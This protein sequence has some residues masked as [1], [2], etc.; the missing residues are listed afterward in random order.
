MIFSRFFKPK[1][2]HKDPDVRRQ[3]LSDLDASDP[4][5]R[6]LLQELAQR[7]ASADVRLAALRRVDDPQWWREAAQRDEAP[8]VRER[9]W[10]RYVKLFAGEGS[11]PLEER[12]SRLASESDRLVEHVLRHGREADLRRAALTRLERESAYAERVLKDEDPAIRLEALARIGD[13]NTLERLLKQTRTRDKRVATAIKERLAALQA[14]EERP[15]VLRQRAAALCGG[16]D[17]L[18][19]RARLKGEWETAAEQAAMHAEWDALRGECESCGLTDALA[20]FGPRYDHARARLDEGYAAYASEQAEQRARAALYEPLREEKAA[21][22]AA[23][24]RLLQDLGECAAP[25]RSE[26]DYA[27]RAWAVLQNNWRELEPLPPQEEQALQR[28]YDEIAAAVEAELADIAAYRGASA[29]LIE[30]TQE[31]ARLLESTQIDGATLARVERRWRDL[32]RPARRLLAGAE[33]FERHVSELRERVSRAEAQRA[34]SR[35]QVRALVRRMDE[36]MAEGHT[37]LAEDLDRQI[38]QALNDLPQSERSAL[39]ETTLR[40]HGRLRTKLREL[41]GWRHWGGVPAKEQLIEEME[42]LRAHLN[43]TPA[44]QIDWP[45][46]ARRIR[47][48]QEQWRKIGPSESERDLWLRFKAACDAAYAPCRERFDTEAQQRAESLARAVALCERLEAF[49]VDAQPQE[50]DVH[51]AERL[52]NEAQREWRNVG[53]LP[54]SAREAAQRRYR[55]AV[56]RLRKARQTA[57]EHNRERKAALIEQVRAL[58]PAGEDA[59]TGRNAIMDA[60][61]AWKSIGPAQGE[62]ELWTAFRAACD[63]WFEGQDAA[64]A[65]RQREKEE[66]LRLRTQWCERAEAL[67]AA[68]DPETA[69]Q[70][71]AELEAQWRDAAPVPKGED[72]AL[73]ERWRKAVAH[74]E[75]RGKDA[76]RRRT[77]EAQ[78]R[79]DALARLCGELER[80]ADAA[81]RAKAASGSTPD[82]EIER[83]WQELAAQERVPAQL[84]ERYKQARGWLA[85]LRGGD[86]T[87]VGSWREFQQQC[88]RAKEELCL[89]AEIAAGIASPPAYQEAR[90][91]Y[92]VARLARVMTGEERADETEREQRLRMAWIALA[93]VPGEE[94]TLAPRFNAALDALQNRK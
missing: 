21:L 84:A 10:E 52:L 79:L 41:L 86:E 61:A 19:E 33:E 40:Q 71:L 16:L 26:E 35:E 13:K 23:V 83:R 85:R 6:A 55:A 75:K 3:A 45:G 57:R 22:L 27:V 42:A 25:G 38:A 65:Q 5:Q 39:G 36:A 18:Y 20:E 88:R 62:R 31:S 81:A 9:A 60:Q 12:L 70:E 53:S 1:W 4:A 11:W 87:A 46:T 59:R 67:A 8:E 63:A 69:R 91:R 24:Q 29:A 2:Q 66:A 82:E 74:L 68:A 28:Q 17:A 30:L 49:P 47:A 80:R 76:A 48:A 34:A 78:D 43:A 93:H 54:S 37:R 92:Q 64:R 56:E 90:M 32:P 77:H 50:T 7:D 15:R 14:A 58:T 51:G 44:E 72:R 89:E 73:R 94:E